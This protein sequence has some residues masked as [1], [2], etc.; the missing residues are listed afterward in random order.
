MTPSRSFKSG[1][2]RGKLNTRGPPFLLEHLLESYLIFCYINSMTSQV[3]VPGWATVPG[4]VDRVF[5][6][7]WVLFSGKVAP[8]SAG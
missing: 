6:P 3:I 5:T 1:I 2:N 7:S 4:T 8:S